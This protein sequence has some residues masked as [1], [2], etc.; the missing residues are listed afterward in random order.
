VAKAMILDE[1]RNWRFGYGI[2]LKEQSIF[3]KER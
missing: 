3:V 1:K 2:R